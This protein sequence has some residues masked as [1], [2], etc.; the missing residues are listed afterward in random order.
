MVDFYKIFYRMEL[1][2]ELAMIFIWADNCPGQFGCAQN[3]ATVAAADED[4]GVLI[5]QFFPEKQC[6]KNIVDNIGKA[7]PI[8][9]VFDATCA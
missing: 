6:F 5:S 2:I 8:Y 1:G 4:W 3:Y 7:S 9:F